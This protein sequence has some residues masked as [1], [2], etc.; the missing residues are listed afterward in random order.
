MTH[1]LRLAV[2]WPSTGRRRRPAAAPADEPPP[3]DEDAAQDAFRALCTDP[4]QVNGAALSAADL[5]RRA[6]ALRAVFDRPE[7]EVPDVA[8]A[9]GEVAVAFRLSGRQVGPLTTAAG[10]LATLD[11]VRL[12]PA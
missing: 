9:D 12:S 2:D 3:D 1:G 8:R 4:V 10:A 6:R 11:A 7:P 5:V